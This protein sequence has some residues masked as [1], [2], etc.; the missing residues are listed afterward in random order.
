MVPPDD[1]LEVSDRRVCTKL[2]GAAVWHGLLIGAGNAGKPPRT[3]TCLSPGRV[4]RPSI[5]CG[6]TGYSIRSVAFENVNK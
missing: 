5:I 4:E 1:V 2:I 3:V 6:S